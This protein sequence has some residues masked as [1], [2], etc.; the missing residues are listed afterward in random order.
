MCK[1]HEIKKAKFRS[2]YHKKLF[3]AIRY[4]VCFTRIHLFMFTFS[5]YV[6]SVPFRTKVENQ[7]KLKKC[8]ALHSNCAHRLLLTVDAQI[9]SITKDA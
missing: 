6:N 9:L 1:I 2:F 5:N 3:L 7:H 8:N 4:F